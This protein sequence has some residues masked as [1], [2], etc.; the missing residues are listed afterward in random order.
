MHPIH[1]R[2]PV[3]LP[4]DQYGLWLD[5]RFQDT[6]KLLRPYPWTHSPTGS[7]PWSTTPGTTC[8]SASRRSG[9][10]RRLPTPFSS[11][12][13]SRPTRFCTLRTQGYPSRARKR[14]GRLEVVR[15]V[16][17]LLEEYGAET[18]KGLVDELL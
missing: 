3:V 16:K 18:A 6:E 4:P 12:A 13:D 9:E 11:A 5:P 1:E 7:A 14:R 15:A 8:R 10:Y 2:M 17:A